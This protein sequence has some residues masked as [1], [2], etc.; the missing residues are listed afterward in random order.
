MKRKIQLAMMLGILVAGGCSK[1]ETT[2]PDNTNNGGTSSASVSFKVDGTKIEADSAFAVL[3]TFTIPPHDRKIDVFAFKGGALVLEGH[4]APKTGAQTIGTTT[5]TAMLTYKAGADLSEYYNSKS[6][7]FSF[8]ECDT[9]GN[10]L[11]AT[12][13]FVGEQLMG[14][15]GTKNITEGSIKLSSLRRQ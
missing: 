15:T 3:Y 12:F 10:K 11:T 7:N 13:D 8:S 2:T 5:A 14:G 6:G 9:V 4:F 1:D